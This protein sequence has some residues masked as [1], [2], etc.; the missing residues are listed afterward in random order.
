MDQIQG[1]KTKRGRPRIPLR[2]SR[3]FIVKP[4]AIADIDIFDLE[5]DR[6]QFDEHYK[7]AEP[8]SNNDWRLLFDPDAFKG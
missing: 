7:D 4:Q 2:W 6:E 8:S 3:V 1:T 5:K